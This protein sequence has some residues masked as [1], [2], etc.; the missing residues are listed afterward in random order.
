MP[1]HFGIKG[2]NLFL[3]LAAFQ[4]VAS[5]APTGTSTAPSPTSLLGYNPANG[6]QFEDTDNIQFSLLPAQTQDANIGAFLDFNG[7]ENPQPIRGSRGGL[8][9]GPRKTEYDVLNPDKLAPPGT[10]HGSVSNAEWPL[11][12]SHTKMG[13]GRAGWSR[14]QNVDNIPAATEMA[15]VDM[16]LEA[17]GYRELHWH[18]AAEW[19]YVL[20]GSVRIQAVTEDG[21]TFVDDLSAGDVWFFPA[22]VPHSLQALDGGVEFLLVFDDGSFS[23]DSTFL[24]TEV[25][26]RNPKSVLSKNFGGLPLSAWDNI[27]SGELF[28]FPGTPAPKDI[29]EQN[30][31][32]SAGVLPVEQSYSYHLS[33]AG[34]TVTTA[35]G[36]VKIIDPKSFPI[37]SMFSAAVVTIKPGAVRE[38]HWH[39]TSD[40]WNFFIS[41]D[42]R[43]GIYAAEGN[44]RTFNYHAGDCG[45]IPKA[46]SHYVENIG[47]D[48]VVFIEVLQA[49]HFSDISLGQWVGLTP[50]QIIM[51]TLN[52]TNSTVSQFKKEKQYVVQG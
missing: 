10:D 23:E 7:V 50:P 13:L 52:L 37:A 8:D 32:G 22:G 6:V 29:A 48:D 39:T 11:G 24:A 4:Q 19:S 35:G 25:F 3:A 20:N 33:K 15:G 47:K 45:Y 14:E 1:S 27:P 26:A 18:T 34:P 36:S 51:D 49:D 43:I 16:R 42:A 21:Q 44:A 30:I 40:E 28:I 9:P 2:A 46:M 41:G 31:V 5:G 12:L 38:I 17:G